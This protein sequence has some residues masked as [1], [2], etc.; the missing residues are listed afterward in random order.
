MVSAKLL[1]GLAALR[2]EQLATGEIPSYVRTAHGGV[3]Y[4][5][6]PFVSIFVHDELGC[7]DSQSPWWDEGAAGLV[8][9]GARERFVDTVSHVRRAIRRFLAWQQECDGTWRGYGRGSGMDPDA[10]TTAGAAL[11]LLEHRGRRPG[12]HGNGGMEPLLRFRSADDLYF[13]FVTRDGR[14]YGWQDETGHRRLGFDRVVNAE[15]LRYLWL[16]GDSRL[17]ADAL[18]EFLRHEAT[19]GDVRQGSA[20]YPNPLCFYYALGRAWRQ[21]RLPEPARLASAVVPRILARQTA[22]GDFGNPLSTALAAAALLEFGHEGPA[23]EHARWA[24][25]SAVP[26]WHGWAADDFMLHG[27]GSPACLVALS[28]RVLAARVPVARYEA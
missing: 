6:G 2:S 7:F 4:R 18:V 13:T 16:S 20:L 21:A 10:G 15:V 9:D 23:L 24:M 19:D 1:N 11:A 28:M 3:E 25:V 5:R 12:L 27:L 26:S 22:A 17:A 14:G 8:A